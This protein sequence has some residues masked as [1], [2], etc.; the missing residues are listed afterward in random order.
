MPSLVRRPS[1]STLTLAWSWTGWRCQPISPTTWWLTTTGEREVSVKEDCLL[2]HTCCL[3]CNRFSY[4]NSIGD[5]LGKRVAQYIKRYRDA[6]QVKSGL[7]E[8]LTEV[9][10]ASNLSIKDKLERLCPHFARMHILYDKRPNNT[11]PQQTMGL[12]ANGI[13]LGGLSKNLIMH[14]Q[15]NINLDWMH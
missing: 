11:P 4:S 3:T 15:P 7:G 2:V 1:S 12:K 10:V 13:T 8:G 14:V 5:N 6:L 9:E